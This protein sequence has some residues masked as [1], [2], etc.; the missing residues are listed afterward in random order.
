MGQSGNG[1][2]RGTSPALPLFFFSIATTRH[3]ITRFTFMIN[4]D[5]FHNFVIL[6]LLDSFGRD[7]DSMARKRRSDPL[8]EGL[9]SARPTPKRIEVIEE[10]V[11]VVTIVDD[12]M[13]RKN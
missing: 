6:F 4:F 7:R 1:N 5:F 12:A 3:V 11:E 10:P 9:S 8:S 13:V 2:D